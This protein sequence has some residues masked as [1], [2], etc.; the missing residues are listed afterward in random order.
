MTGELRI[1][2]I[3]IVSNFLKEQDNSFDSTQFWLEISS[4]FRSL[5]NQ[6]VR[7][8]F[9]QEHP[10]YKILTKFYPDPQNYLWFI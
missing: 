10:N 3:E 4:H 1:L 6:L 9:D 2:E 7:V 5:S 8:A